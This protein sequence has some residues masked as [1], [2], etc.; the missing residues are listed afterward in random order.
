MNFL[1]DIMKGEGEQLDSGVLIYIYVLRDPFTNSIRYV[2]QTRHPKKRRWEHIQNSRT[3]LNEKCLW[4]SGLL[5]DGHR[6][7]IEIVDAVPENEWIFWEREYVKYF[8][9]M[10][11]KL[12]NAG[13]GGQGLSKHTLE[14]RIKIS[15]AGKGRVISAETRK[16]MADARRGKSLT[17][18]HRAALKAAWKPKHFSLEARKRM[19]D[20]HKGNKYMVGRKLSEQAKEKK[21]RY[22]TGK[23]MALGHRHTEEFKLKMSKLMSERIVSKETREKLSIA[24][25]GKA[26]SPETRIKISMAH[27]ARN[28]KIT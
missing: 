27:R 23:K 4:I 14:T 1:T 11:C 28:A 2:G 13:E 26:V 16:K 9:I 24:N 12:T 21:R 5:I 17:P 3:G 10:G 18:E 8:K 22:M 20:A 25:T 6:P 15:N 7:C 19:S